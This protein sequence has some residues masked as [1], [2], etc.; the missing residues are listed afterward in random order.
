MMKNDNEARDVLGDPRKRDYRA[1]LGRARNNS[2]PHE[3]PIRLQDLP[4]CPQRTN[5]PQK[6]SWELQQQVVTPMPESSFLN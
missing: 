2:G 1:H 6:F 3:E 4:L 5:K